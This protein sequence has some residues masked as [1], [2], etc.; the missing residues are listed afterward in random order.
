MADTYKSIRYVECTD[1]LDE[2]YPLL[3]GTFRRQY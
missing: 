1:P 3:W 2:V